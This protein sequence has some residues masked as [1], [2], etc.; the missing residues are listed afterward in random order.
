MSLFGADWLVIHVACV[1]L[2]LWASQ[3]HHYATL[4]LFRLEVYT[5]SMGLANG[6]DRRLISDDD[7]DSSDVRSASFIPVWYH[8]YEDV[9]YQSGVSYISGF[10]DTL[11]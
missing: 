3:P 7:G 6:M 1:I 10:K 4:C 8:W 11:C 5:A 9:I 2:P